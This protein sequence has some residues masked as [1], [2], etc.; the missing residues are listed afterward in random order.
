MAVA[1]S[2]Q[3]A[4]SFAMQFAKAAA[5]PVVAM[6]ARFFSQTARVA[7]DQ[8]EQNIV[9]DAVKSTE[10][11][12]S[13]QETADPTLKSTPTM[14][15]SAAQTEGY[16]VFVSNM[17]FDAT[18]MHLR[19]AFGKYGDI[20]A[21]KIGRDGRGLSRGFGFITFAEK[22]AADRAVA[23]CNKSFWHGRRINVEHRK[24]KD[25]PERQPSR[26]DK[27]TTSLYIG[28][29]PY[30]TSDADLNRLFRELDGV[31]DVRVAVDRNTGWPR[32]F[33]HADFVDLESAIKGYEKVANT[34]MGG[35]MLKVDYS[36]KRSTNDYR[37]RQGSRGPR[38]AREFRAPRDS[39]F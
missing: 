6:P 10:G 36:E 14:S 38:E 32:G 39:A 17:T 25:L 24:S 1:A 7:Q 2:R 15:E 20:S 19:E 28:N 34:S 5:R 23:E 30:E 16:P 4:S 18:D 9:D 13:T 12:G 27:P 29:I 8:T 37:D 26:P 33:A 21:I 22:S 3:Q 31:T 35:R 11:L